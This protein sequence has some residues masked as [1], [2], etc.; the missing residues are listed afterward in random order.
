VTFPM[1]PEARVHAVKGY[2]VGGE[3]PTV[4]QFERWLTRD[5][6]LTRG[7]AQMVTTK[8]YAA[9]LRERDAAP[10][11]DHALA[12]SMH[13]ASRFIHPEQGQKN[14]WNFNRCA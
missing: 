11:N 14:D 9:L 13:A 1:Q 6:G 2:G 12:R 4:R 3:L 10:D 5:A 8:G 7:D